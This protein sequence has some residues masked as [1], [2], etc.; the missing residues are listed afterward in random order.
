MNF[1]SLAIGEL[2]KFAYLNLN[3]IMRK[4][5]VYL[6]FICITTMVSGYGQLPIKEPGHELQPLTSLVD[7]TLQQE[8]ERAL[9]KNP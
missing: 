7:R 3:Y 6:F 2:H 4:R 9:L 5:I 1:N 8:V